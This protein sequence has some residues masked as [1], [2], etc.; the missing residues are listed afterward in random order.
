MTPEIHLHILAS[1]SKGNAT[2]V[3]GPDGLVL[4]DCGLSRKLLM[5]RAR[6]LG[7]SCDD[8]RAVLVTHEHSDHVSGISVFAR[9]FDGPFFATASTIA[10][11]SYLMEIPFELVNHSD[12]LELA[13]MRVQCFPTSHDVAD[14]MCFRFETT[15]DAIGY[16]TDTGVLTPEAK[17][18]LTGVRVLA[19]ESNHDPQ[20]LKSGPYPGYLKARVGGSRGHLSNTQAAE[21]LP[22]LIGP[23]TEIVIGMHLSQENNRPSLAVRAMAQA[24]GAVTANSTFTEARTPDGRLSICAASQDT[25][26]TIW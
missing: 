12:T 24:V 21:A 15:H 14:P 4:I 3:E 13:G 2:L 7:V 6:E 23:S 25:P 8:I 20:M 26:I 9:R 1:G 18:A 22:E 11:R 10:A 16:C 19:L 17:A 5:E